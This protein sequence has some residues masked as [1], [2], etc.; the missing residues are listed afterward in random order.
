MLALQ[1]VLDLLFAQGGVLQDLLAAVDE[2]V[3]LDHSL[4]HFPPGL[5]GPYVVLPDAV[6]VLQQLEDVLLE[7]IDLVLVGRVYLQDLGPVLVYFL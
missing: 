5:G 1:L 7:V 4:V 6:V 3:V 2:L